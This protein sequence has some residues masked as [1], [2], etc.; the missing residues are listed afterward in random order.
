VRDEEE[1]DVI[2]GEISEDE[3]FEEKCRAKIKRTAKDENFCIP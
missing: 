2:L 1:F 3:N